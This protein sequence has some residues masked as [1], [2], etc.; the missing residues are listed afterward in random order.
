MS[1]IDFL[2]IISTIK[3][4]ANEHFKTGITEN[5]FKY[6]YFDAQKVNRLAVSLIIRTDISVEEQLKDL[7]KSLIKK[8]NE[9]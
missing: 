2:K 9:K 8:I 7:P 6:R 3:E 1:K 4:F 5:G